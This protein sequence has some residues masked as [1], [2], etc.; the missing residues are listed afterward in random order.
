MSDLVINLLIISGLAAG[1]ALLI[2]IARK[3]LADY[4][5]VKIDLNDGAK[6]VTVTGGNNLLFSLMENNIYLPSGCGGRGTCALCKSRVLEGGGPVL[7]TELPYL[8]EED[9]KEGVRLSCQVKL[10]EDVKIQVPE[11]LFNIKEF[12]VV[13]TEKVPM[14]P[15]IQAVFFKILSP[16]EGIQFKPGQF[17]QLQMPKEK[18]PDPEYRAYSLCS[19]CVDNHDV[20]LLITKVPEGMVS[21][22]VH[23]ELEVGDKLSLIGPFGDFYY[24]DNTNDMLLISTGSG[25]A[26]IRSILQHVEMEHIPRNMTLFFGARTKPDLLYY[27]ELVERA[28]RMDNFTYMPVLSRA[29]EADQWEG[30]TG[31]VTDL[32]ERYV[33]QDADIEVYMCGNPKMI[34]SCDKLLRAKGV[35][36]ILYDSFD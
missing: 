21:G 16:E 9:I 12:Q 3:Y 15:T 26:P 34:E 22:Y 10:R 6:E 13:V 35:K 23:E 36:S 29:S 25:L 20:E 19:A 18:S 5:E 24:Q 32:I 8:S 14:S 1:L 28:E 17:V 4:G 30:E 2:E 7:P 27:D 31:R 33:K 11:E